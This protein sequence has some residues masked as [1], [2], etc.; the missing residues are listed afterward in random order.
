M[1]RELSDSVDRESVFE[2]RLV[3][4]KQDGLGEQIMENPHG[5]MECTELVEESFFQRYMGVRTIPRY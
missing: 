4:Q 5:W 1:T 3:P 2:E